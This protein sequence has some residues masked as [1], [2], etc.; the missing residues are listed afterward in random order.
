MAKGLYFIAL[1][2]AIIIVTRALFRIAF[3]LLMKKFIEKSQQQQQQY[4]KPREEGSVTVEKKRGK[5]KTFGKEDGEY[6]KYED[7]D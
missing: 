6:V 3:P 2:V 1:L 7:V 5:D 4:S